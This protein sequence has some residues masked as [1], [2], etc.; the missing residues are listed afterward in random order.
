MPVEATTGSLS[1]V[2]ATDG[3]RLQHEVVGEGEPLVLLHGSYSG[4]DA[5]KRQVPLLADHFRLI[6]RDLRG[7]NGAEPRIPADYAIETT[8]ID[9]LLS[10][11]DAVGI[12]S[13]H[14]V[15]HS[16]GAAI[17]FAFARRHPGRV[18]RLVLIEPPFFSLLPP[19]LHR[20]CTDHVRGI[21]DLADRE[22]PLAASRAVFTYVLGPG[23]ERAARSALL[24]QMEA[25]APLCPYFQRSLL[26][27]TVSDADI[28][29][30]PVPTLY[31]HGR[32]TE[33]IH[34]AMYRRI[35]ELRPEAPDLIVEGAGHAVHLQ[36]AAIVGEAI[37][38]FLRPDAARER[39]R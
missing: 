28:S 6:L 32:A 36:R 12:D 24:A 34:T 11:L 38:S 31:I 39:V 16:S 2:D 5:F 19:G 20:E 37:L 1:F 21:I 29:R 17:A 3:A 35:A 33:S 25:A 23:W 15:G 13:A 14:L 9:D 22:G 18:R 27:L 7:H 8:E 4:R 10:V 30:P 26:A